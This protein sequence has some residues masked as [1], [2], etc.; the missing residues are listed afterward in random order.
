MLR[1]EVLGFDPAQAAVSLAQTLAAG[2]GGGLI[3]GA[4]T[5]YSRPSRLTS[6]VMCSDVFLFTGTLVGTLTVEVCNDGD[7]VDQ[8]GAADWHTY[9]QVTGNGFAAG[10]APVAAGVITGG[11]N[12]GSVQLTDMGFAAYRYKFVVTAGAGTIKDRRVLKGF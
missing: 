5:Y 4:G 7:G 3:S 11:T 2:A 12:P 9:D 8:V 10:A 1:G 6:T